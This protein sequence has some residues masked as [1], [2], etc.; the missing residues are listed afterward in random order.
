M[1]EKEFN[2]A[3]KDFFTETEAAHYCGVSLRH[4]QRAHEVLRVAGVQARKVL[5]KKLYVRDELA[6]MIERAPAWYSELRPV[7]SPLPGRFGNL[8]PARL[9]PY[10]P[11]KPI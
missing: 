10:R 11:R 8:A 9:R 3:G 7:Y 5:G 1:K 6:R 2:L 4:F